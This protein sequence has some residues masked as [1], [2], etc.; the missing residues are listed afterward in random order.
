MGPRSRSAAW[1]PL[2]AVLAALALGASALWLRLETPAIRPPADGRSGDP[3]PA[4]AALAAPDLGPFERYDVNGDNPFVPWDDRVRE[5]AK[6]PPPPPG[7]PPPRPPSDVPLP[8]RPPLH[9]PGTGT[10]GG[11]APRAL[12]FV[13]AGADASGLLVRLPGESAS[14]LLQPGGR[15]GRWTLVA[16]EDG[17]IAVFADA[18]GR[19]YR[20][21]IGR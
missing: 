2:A 3:S 17:N 14:R 7:P 11:D 19:R 8:P 4:L 13:R 12:G 18:E 6:P 9:L 20:Q 21:L 16:I 15:A 1:E 10:G 5:G